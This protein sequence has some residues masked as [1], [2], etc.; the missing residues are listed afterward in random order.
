MC[1]V[2][3]HPLRIVIR[4]S[5]TLCVS[6]GKGNEP[7]Q[8]GRMA[9]GMVD[10]AKRRI[11]FVVRASRREKSMSELCKEAKIS[12]P[13]GYRWLRR[14]EAGGLRAVVEKSRCPHHRPTRTAKDSEQR[15]VEL[16]QK[17]PDWGARKLHW[18]LEKDGFAL[19]V[20][21]IHRI[22][23]RNGL[24]RPQDRHRSAVQRFSRSAPNQLWQM[25]FKGPVGWQAPVG[26]LSI[27]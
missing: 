4:T 1:T 2:S 8:E 15:I 26:P 3:G 19:P 20:I 9:W 14:F 12:R 18:L 27:L 13:T 10:V 23:L 7:L 17:R 16:R 24:V 25:D 11:D 21:T 5:F 22:L 6:G